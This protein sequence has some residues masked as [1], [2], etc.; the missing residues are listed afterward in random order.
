MK[1]NLEAKKVALDLVKLLENHWNPIS[2]SFGAVTL[3]PLA[4]VKDCIQFYTT[5]SG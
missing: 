4:T 5:S 2:K 1:I 3:S